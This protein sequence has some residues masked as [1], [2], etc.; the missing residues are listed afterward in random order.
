MVIAERRQHGGG[1]WRSATHT[2]GFN[3][4]CRRRFQRYSTSYLQFVACFFSKACN[5]H[6]PI[7]HTH[8]HAPFISS[9][10]HQRP[11]S[12]AWGA[13]DSLTS[14]PSLLS[15]SLLSYDRCY[16]CAAEHKVA[17]LAPR[18]CPLTL[19]SCEWKALSL[20]RLGRGWGWRNRAAPVCDG[21]PRLERRP[22]RKRP[23]N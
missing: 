13:M 14:S 20:T 22:T 5:T 12:A 7:T 19:E 21:Q 11:S 1:L 15:A 17:L 3:S 6:M 10:A 16:V 2:S 4:T 23:M 8:T 9:S 18:L